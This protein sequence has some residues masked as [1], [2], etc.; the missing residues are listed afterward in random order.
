[1]P[2]PH[3]EDERRLAKMWKLTPEQAH[4]DI[5]VR[6]MLQ[7]V[8]ARFIGPEGVQ[9]PEDGETLEIFIK[10]TKGNHRDGVRITESINIRQRG[11]V[12]PDGTR[13]TEIG[14]YSPTLGDIAA[15]S[16][17]LQERAINEGDGPIVRAELTVVDP[18]QSSR[19]ARLSYLERLRGLF[20]R[21]IFRSLPSARR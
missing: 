1:M 15:N 19:F 10:R 9:P 5:M 12:Y 18:P 16:H 7:E 21:S 13:H 8:A 3:T 17:S 14:V 4:D 6:A 11:V 2:A 20:D